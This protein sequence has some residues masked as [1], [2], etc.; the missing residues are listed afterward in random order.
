MSAT[1]LA[2]AGNWP[3]LGTGTNLAGIGLFADCAPVAV[4]A[5]AAG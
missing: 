5:G 2:T 3:A 1:I 4:P